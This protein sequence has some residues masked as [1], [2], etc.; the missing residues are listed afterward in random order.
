M[1]ECF[2]AYRYNNLVYLRT[3]KC[4]S[5][6]YYKLFEANGWHKISANDIDWRQDHV[7]SFIMNPFI[8]R[9]KGFVEVISTTKNWHLLGQNSDF[10]SMLLYLDLHSMPYTLSYGDF[11]NKIDW[12]PI[13]QTYSS[14]S[15]LEKLLND[16]NITLNFTNALTFKRESSASK[17]KLYE[18]IK[19]LSDPCSAETFILVNNDM[20][21]YEKVLANINVDG[22]TWK[23]CSWLT[24]YNK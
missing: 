15:L 19:Q 12:I 22:K 16:Y 4:A 8:R 17:L 24:N 3:L 23:E 2:E 21:L 7:F 9:L 11:V 10:W 6:Y 14:D 1:L 13:D 5:T 18:T 20:I